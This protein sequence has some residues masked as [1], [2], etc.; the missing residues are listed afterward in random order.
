[1][2]HFA[3][4]RQEV[5]DL[6][7]IGMLAERLMCTNHCPA[8]MAVRAAADQFEMLDALQ[9]GDAVFSAMRFSKG[10]GRKAQQNVLA[11]EGSD[12]R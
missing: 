4:L 1:M 6:P 10:L 2:Y 5:G 3:Q 8:A 12:E 7:L 9:T 11:I